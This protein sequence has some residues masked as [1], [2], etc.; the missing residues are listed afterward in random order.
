MLESMARIGGI[1]DIQWATVP[2]PLGSLTRE[3]LRER[4]K[5]ALDQFERIVVARRQK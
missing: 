1:P 4:A 3:E 5:Q 2:H